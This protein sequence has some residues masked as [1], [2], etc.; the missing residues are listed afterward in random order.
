MAKCFVITPI[1]E[2]GSEIRKRTDEL[3][4]SI[5]R[6]TLEEN[7]FEPVVPHEMDETGSITNQIIQ[8]IVNDEMVVANLTGLNPNVM[9][10][11]AI[12]HCFAKPV[13]CVLE[14]GTKLPF[15][16]S[17][18]RAVYYENS[19]GGAIEL[20]QN[21][22]KALDAAISQTTVDNPVTRAV[23]HGAATADTSN[24][25]DNKHI[26][27]WNQL[28]SQAQNK[29]NFCQRAAA[30]VFYFSALNELLEC[31]NQS[32][33]SDFIKETS[34]K[35]LGL[36]ANME[37]NGKLRIIDGSQPGCALIVKKTDLPDIDKL[38]ILD[39]M[40]R[41]TA[42]PKEFDE[43]KEALGQPQTKSNK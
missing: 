3:L 35:I 39:Y 30:L 27:R 40:Q 17:A 36:F 25:E 9:Y 16:I 10:E 1:G 12:R 20:K 42:I 5:I 43:L 32:T 15:D 37:K 33:Y 38:R 29:L 19:I 7:G 14:I 24:V 23:G 22:R 34:D 8:H 4:N 6:P 21:L 18:D 41:A 13:V 28:M 2:K 26:A 11:L 31:S